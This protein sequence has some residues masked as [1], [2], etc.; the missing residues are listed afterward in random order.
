MA[1]EAIWNVTVHSDSRMNRMTN[2][3]N[4][5]SVLSGLDKTKHGLLICT[6]SGGGLVVD[7]LY[8]CNAAGDALI[9][10]T[11]GAGHYH[12]SSTDGGELINIFRENPQFFDLALTRTNDLQKANW[13]QS[14][15]STGT[16]A[17]DTDGSTSER[18]IKLLTGTTTGS[19]STIHYPHLKLDFSRKAMF[20]FKARFSSATGV[21]AHSGVGADRV[22]SADSNLRKFQAEVCTATNT[23]WF[24]RCA[25]GSANSSSDTGLAFTTNRVGVR[26]DHMPDLSTPEVDIYVD[27]DS[28]ATFQKTSHIATSGATGSD[29]LIMHSLKNN[30]AADKNYFIYGSRLRYTVSDNWF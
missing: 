26:I 16:I 4:T 5:G 24:I 15:T 29:N 19:E 1:N 14:T 22:V 10:I 23:N 13:N 2:I 11:A 20:Q 17:D 18:A 9:D 6:S 8:M 12:T 28:S 27:T 3:P 30:S 25:N 7:H 21:A